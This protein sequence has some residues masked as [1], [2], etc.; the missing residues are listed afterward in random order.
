MVFYVFLEFSELYQ[1]RPL[2]LYKLTKLKTLFTL[3]RTSII[4]S[5][6]DVKDIFDLSA[7]YWAGTGLAG[8]KWATGI[9][10]IFSGF[11]LPI[12]IS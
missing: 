4:D 6:R 1:F 5:E 8:A 7:I 3:M 11:L 9:D 10:T 12:A 2:L